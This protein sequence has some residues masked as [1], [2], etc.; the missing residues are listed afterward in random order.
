MLLLLVMGAPCCGKS[1]YALSLRQQ[2]PSLV[3]V[4]SID[5]RYDAQVRRSA[6]SA[7][8]ALP[9]PY[10]FSPTAWHQS[11]TEALELTAQ[12]LDGLSLSLPPSST[13]S[14][15]SPPS[16]LIV[17]DDVFHLRSMR[18]PYY[19]LCRQRQIPFAQLL[20]DAPLSLCLAR[21]AA[22]TSSS[23]SGCTSPAHSA[24]TAEVVASLHGAFERPTS[25]E[26]KFTLT[27]PASTALPSLP[28]LLSTLSS[29]PFIPPPLPAPPALCTTRTLQS[30]LHVLDLSLRR[31]IS[32]HIAAHSPSSSASSS[33]SSCASPIALNSLRRQLLV[34][35]K[36]PGTLTHSLLHPHPSDPAVERD[37]TTL[38]DDQCGGEKGSEVEAEV[39]QR[40][41]P[42]L[43]YFSQLLL[44]SA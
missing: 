36:L 34:D 4:V 38:A 7:S 32:A 10:P 31:L 35:A 8:S 6:A 19:R 12:L 25:Y 5:D 43:L 18:S 44:Q 40:L 16:P 22:R 28:A 1:S 11:R 23:S 17:V 20:I 33:S 29:S 21:H 37:P 26:A 3:C 2:Q 30:D 42:V 39:R 24:L 41:Q 9:S 27:A 13:V 15:A 14:P